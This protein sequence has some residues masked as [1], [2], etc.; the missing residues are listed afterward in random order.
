MDPVGIFDSG[1]GGLSV[2]AE[3]RK[4]APHHPVV[5]LADQAWAPYGERSLGEVR[6]RAV[7]ITDHL[8]GL[9]PLWTN[10]RRTAVASEPLHP[11]LV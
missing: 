1:V 8:A 3:F 9:A 11:R 6:D 7:A 4:L 5:Y 2:L 10:S